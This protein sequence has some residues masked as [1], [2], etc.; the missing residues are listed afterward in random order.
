MHVDLV[1]IDVVRLQASQTVLTSAFDTRAT[2]RTFTFE[3]GHLFADLAGQHDV[4]PRVSQPEPVAD[5]LLCATAQI[6]FSS[7]WID[8]RCVEQRHPGLMSDVHDRPRV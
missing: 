5:D 3:A 4:V 2:Q 1:E 8:V 7:G 6:R